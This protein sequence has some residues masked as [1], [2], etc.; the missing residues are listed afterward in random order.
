MTDTPSPQP[1]Y[2]VLMEV[3]RVFL[4]RNMKLPIGLIVAPEIVAAAKREIQHCHVVAVDDPASFQ[5]PKYGGFLL[6]TYTPESA[7]RLGYLR[8]LD[9][10]GHNLDAQRHAAGLRGAEPVR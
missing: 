9:N 10:I 8:A 3:R 5:S 7:Y 1:I 2:T 4:E 6:A